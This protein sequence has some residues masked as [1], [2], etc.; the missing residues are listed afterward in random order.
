MLPEE[1]ARNN[2]LKLK[3]GYQVVGVG[4]FAHTR[5]TDQCDIHGC[6]LLKI[7]KL[8]Q[9]NQPKPETFKGELCFL[10]P[11]LWLGQF[12]G[13]IDPGA[14]LGKMVSWG[15]RK[16]ARSTTGLRS[17]RGLPN[18]ADPKGRDHKLHDPY[19]IINQAGK[20]PQR[21]QDKASQAQTN[22]CVQ[23]ASL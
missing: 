12:K 14:G 17:R 21:E 10:S 11:S 4:S 22:D 16:L 1:L 8:A 5:R 9:K 18:Q 13:I 6:F 3:L 19:F 23:P 7:L 20:P 2:M 15:L